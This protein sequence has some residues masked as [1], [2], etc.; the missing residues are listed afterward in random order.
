MAAE[1]DSDLREVKEE[2]RKRLQQV[3]FVEQKSLKHQ[4]KTSTEKLQKKLL[5]PIS[6]LPLNKTAIF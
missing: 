6:Y 1:L 3:K 4:T 2:D 5:K